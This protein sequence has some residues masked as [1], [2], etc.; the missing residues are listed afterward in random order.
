[1]KNAEW[2][3]S[4]FYFFSKEDEIKLLSGF[5]GDKNGTDNQKCLFYQWQF[6]INKNPD[7]WT[8]LWLLLNNLCIKAIQ[9]ECSKKGLRFSKKY[10]QEKAEDAC[11]YLLGRYKK[12]RDKGEFYFYKNFISQAYYSTLNV[13]YYESKK[14]Q[15]NKGFVS[16]DSLENTVMG[17]YGF[18]EKD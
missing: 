5:E 15:F 16:L 14:E 13:L 10:I 2:K 17:E 1:M 8:S 9:K 3:Q 4:E 18:I 11:I 6:L 12:K 7:A